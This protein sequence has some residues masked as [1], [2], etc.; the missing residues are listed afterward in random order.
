VKDEVE[1][2]RE[3]RNGEKISPEQ[4]DVFPLEGGRFGRVAY[5]CPDFRTLGEEPVNKVASDEPRPAGHD[6]FHSPDSKVIARPGQT[7]PAPGLKEREQR[8]RRIMKIN[9]IAALIIFSLLGAGAAGAVTLTM[10]VGQVKP[11]MKGKGKSVFRGAEI[12]EFDAEILGVI[13]NS[14]PKR[15]IILARLSGMGLENT[16]VVQGMSGSPVYIDGKLIGAVAFS[17]P[18]AKEPIA[19]ITPIGE[20]MAISAEKP[21]TAPSA[22]PGIP[23]VSSLSLDQLFEMQKGVLPVPGGFVAQGQAL[24]PIPV[25]LVFGGFPARTLERVTPFFSRL[26]FYP[27]KSG[28]G[29]IEEKPSAADLSLHEGDP[30]TLQLVGGD[31][32]VSAVGTATYVNGTKVLAFGHPLYNLGAV[33]YGMAKAKIITV[34]PSLDNSFKMA[35]TG[36]TIGS[37]TQDRAVGAVGEIGKAPKFVPL[38]VRIVGE[39]DPTREFKLKIVNDKLLTALL[40][41]MSLQALLQSEERSVGDI[42]LEA[43]A[44]VYVE[45]GKVVQ[46]VHLEDLFSGNFDASRSDLAGL[47]TAVVYL[48]TNNDFRDVGINR[49][50]LTVK[51]TEQAALAYLDRVWL[52]KYEASPGEPIGIKVYYRSFRGE[53]HV[54]E[55]P[56]ITPNLPADSEFQLIV[57]DAASMQRVE[58]GQY[59]AAEIV[60]KSLSQLIRLL[61]NLRKNSRIYFK[62]VASKPGLFLRGEEMPNLPPAMKSLFASPRAAS[63]APVELNI[64]TLGEYQLPVPYLFKGM[65]SIPI[66]IRR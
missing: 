5:Q 19:G 59:R 43:Q 15:N 6:G 29:Q 52:D 4:P 37:F 54:E 10:P 24:N 46:A 41:N 38:N 49:I 7:L 51:P 23:F 35:A 34:V 33:D 30:L 13:E 26:G 63:S 36:A 14:R 3:L 58:T 48:L 18:F 42:T 1:A 50:D 32:D 56:L 27:L 12:Q 17:F 45:T 20:M 47:L 40:T 21:K 60:P 66:K 28:G 8:E 64:S 39:K 31:L 55:V 44:D 2:G 16:G 65:V 9:H 62:I 53:V 11:G 61:N 57:G 22:G 25:P